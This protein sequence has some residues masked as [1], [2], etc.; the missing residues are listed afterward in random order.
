MIRC[1]G[2]GCQTEKCCIECSTKNTHCMCE[3][4]EELHYDKELILQKCEYAEE[5]HGT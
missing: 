1:K 3:V 2:A 4:A 5:K